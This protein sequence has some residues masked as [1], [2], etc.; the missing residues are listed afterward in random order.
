MKNKTCRVMA[1]TACLSLLFS[2]C[3]QTNT[4]APENTSV[5]ETISAVTA[6]NNVCRDDIRNDSIIGR[7]NK[8]HKCQ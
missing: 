5:P 6:A 8:E 1:F 3:G 4:A 2:A 7:G